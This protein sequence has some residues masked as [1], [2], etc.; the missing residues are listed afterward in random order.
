MYL[1]LVVYGG[2]NDILSRI[3]C[4]LNYCKKTERVLLL[5]TTKGCYKMNFS[6]YFSIDSN[7]IVY[8]IKKIRYIC[9]KIE[10]KEIY[11]EFLSKKLIDLVD[12][13]ISLKFGMPT[14]TY[15]NK[16][17]DLPKECKKNLLVYS[18]YGGGNGYRLFRLLKIREDIVKYCEEVY[19]SIEKPYISI[20][21][22]HTDYKCDYERLYEDNREYLEDKTIYLG[23]DNKKVVEYFISKGLR[24]VNLTKYPEEESRNLHYSEVETYIKMRDLLCDIYM[25]TRSEKIISNSIGG[26]IRLLRE[27]NNEYKK[28]EKI[29]LE[30]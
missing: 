6:D 28:N 30:K 22:R 3:I 2:F 29:I 12:N 21:V 9:E 19:N 15:N 23:T 5:D 16:G 18:C 14:Y 17:F 7:M 4:L 27:S 8:D 13:K 24:I 11:P 20:Q 25:I 10:E 1:Y 26:F